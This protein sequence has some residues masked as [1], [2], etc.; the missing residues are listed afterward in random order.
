MYAGR[1]VVDERPIDDFAIRLTGGAAD[2]GPRLRPFVARG[3]CPLLRSRRVPRLL[4]RLDVEL[5]ALVVGP[6]DGTLRLRDVAAVVADGRAALVPSELAE[7][8]SSVEATLEGAGASI[9]E[10]G[11]F[12]FDPVAQE[13]VVP[14]GLVGSSDL[15]E[16]DPVLAPP[17]R[18]AVAA[19]CWHET[20][21]PADASPAST[22]VRLLVLADDVVGMD[23][24]T[25]LR[26]LAAMSPTFASHRL[27][28]RGTGDLRGLLDLLRT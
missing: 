18:Y 6:E 15:L 23:R 1:L 20:A 22:L 2:R 16:G 9:V 10:H 28:G 21:L 25:L 3:R 8:S 14:T 5:G 12:R 17:G 11:C 27:T 24:A 4:R 19:I 13:I 26:S 7:R